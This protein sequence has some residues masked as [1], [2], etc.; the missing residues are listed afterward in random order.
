[1]TNPTPA[2]S[3]SAEALESGAREATRKQIRGS[4]LLLF[5]R[6]MSLG[7]NFGV[8]ILIVRYLSK[9]DFGAYAYALSLVSLGVSIATFG[10]DRSITRFIPI[11]EEEKQF[12]KLWGTLVM[13]TSTILSISLALMVLL[14]GLHGVLGVSLISDEQA[15]TLLLI[16][17]VAVPITA[18]D[19]LTLGLFAV[20]SKPRAI[21]FRRYVLAP[22]LRLTVVALLILSGSGVEFLAVGYVLTGAVAVAIYAFLL[23]R[24]MRQSG[25]LDHL[26]VHRLD[27]P[28]REVFGFTVPLL[29]S[30]LL[31]MTMNTSDVLLLGH[32]RGTEAVASLRVILPA[33]H[34]NL[35]VMNS[36]TLLF[37]PVAA[38][39]FARGDREGISHL[40]WQTAAWIAVLSF[41][42]FAL[43]FSLA[44]P[45]TVTLFGER[46][47][48][49][50]TY[51]SLL[52][53]AYYFNA[54]LG[55]NG[56]TLKVFGMV[57]YVLVISLA[58]AVVNLAL[59]F[60]LIPAYGAL[61]AALGTS[62]T[63]I[64]HNILKQV[65][66]R[67]GTGISLFQRQDAVVYASIA[68]CAAALLALNLLFDPSL[69][70]ALFLAAA[71]SVVV[72][73]AS[74]RVLRAGDTFPELARF[75]LIRL[76]V[77]R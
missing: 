6:L 28:F 66:L 47:E 46:Y 41:P 64:V 45:V 24:T 57:R 54:A 21:F 8:Q 55:F 38:R 65:G 16:M 30:D 77:G 63:L 68:A 20:F 29:A 37:T 43:T 73:A 51:L 17:I 27:M 3:A 52:A 31:Y 26:N 25:L 69:W 75:R 42:L 34:L 13:V 33:A 1:V 59:N 11:Y 62:C 12:D 10:L 9:A 7:I 50:A 70:I 15:I 76:I 72:V 48:S 19:G 5:G 67:R 53:L 36:F 23:F 14:Y 61:G 56:L 2:A 58:A 39:L 32:Y 35:L 71:A 40:Y 44:D 18:L 4:S 49:S 22:G 74:R 60:V